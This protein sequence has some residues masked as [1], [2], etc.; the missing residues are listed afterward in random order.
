[1]CPFCKQFQPICSFSTTSSPWKQC[2]P[3]CCGVH[4]S[5]YLY[6]SAHLH[7]EEGTDKPRKAPFEKDSPKV[8]TVMWSLV[9]LGIFFTWKAES[10]REKEKYTETTRDSISKFTLQM[11]TTAWSVP[12]WSQEQRDCSGFL[13]W[14]PGPKYLCPPPLSSHAV[15][16]E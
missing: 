16:R 4:H 6:A 12:V 3:I 13:T 1:M 5:W 7:Y 9:A 15:L 11:V 10:R 2:C 8:I 14:V